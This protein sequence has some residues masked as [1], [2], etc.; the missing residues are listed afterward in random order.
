MKKIL[1]LLLLIYQQQGFTQR[2]EVKFR[3]TLDAASADYRDNYFSSP[4][5]LASDSATCSIRSI[6]SASKNADRR[7]LS[8]SIITPIAIH[9]T[10]TSELTIGFTNGDAY[11]F[12]TRAT[13]K[14]YQPGEEISLYIRMYDE[15]LNELIDNKADKVW[16]HTNDAD[17]VF[18]I[19]KE[20]SENLANMCQL[21][22]NT[23]IGTLSNVPL[24]NP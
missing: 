22:K 19:E 17:Y 6:I 24:G 5:N 16:L 12:I 3:D 8:F 14:Y 13:D 23:D 20:Y 9:A 7:Y 15:S 10:D 11:R 18:K 21:I 4:L 2:I 1:F